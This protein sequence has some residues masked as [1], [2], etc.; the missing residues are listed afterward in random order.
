MFETEWYFEFYGETA[1]F[2]FPIPQILLSLNTV[3]HRTVVV[4]FAKKLQIADEE[5]LLGT[6]L[7]MSVATYS[8]ESRLGVWSE[9]RAG[10]RV[11]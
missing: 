4:S 9:H 7:S 2:A 5:D 8:P 11:P 6:H 3:N 10:F 1:M